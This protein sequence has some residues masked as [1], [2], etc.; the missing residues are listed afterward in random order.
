MKKLATLLLFIGIT[1]FANQVNAQDNVPKEMLL[2]TLNSV[3]SMTKLSDETIGNLMNY[4]KSYVDK[5][6]DIIDSGKSNSYIKN[7]FKELNNQS[8][9][10]LTAIFGKKSVYN[11]YAK[12]MATQLKPLV[13]KTNDLKYIY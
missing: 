1:L 7:A 11:D 5:V 9:K 3:N 6:Y 10:D 8:E 13:K 12:L 2:T 4:N